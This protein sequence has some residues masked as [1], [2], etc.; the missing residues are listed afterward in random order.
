MNSALVDRVVRAVL[1]E[2]YLLYPYRPSALKNR[3]RL[4]FGTVEPGSHLQAEVLI[5]GDAPV[6]NSELRFLDAAGA[7]HRG[8]IDT[9]SVSLRL[10]LWKCTVRV[11]SVTEPI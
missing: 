2:G 3:Q 6:V 10:S 8:P 5:A 11:D 1:Y 9:V 4:S 7:E